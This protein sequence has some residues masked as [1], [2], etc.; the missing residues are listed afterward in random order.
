MCL[1]HM[2]RIYT[3]SH[4]ESEEP[5]SYDMTFSQHADALVDAEIDISAL[6][7]LKVQLS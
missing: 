4:V 6:H 3:S 2:I 1:C 7:L 5:E